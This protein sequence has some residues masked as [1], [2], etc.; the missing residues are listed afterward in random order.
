MT[1]ASASSAAAVPSDRSRYGLAAF[2]V[3]AGVMH[4]VSPG[5]FERIVP[6]WIG[7]EKAV[8]A[9]S[10][11]AEV[12]CGVLLAVP[13]TRRFGAWLTVVTLVAVYPANLQMAVDAGRPQE[14]A[15]WVAWL[16]LPLQFPLIVWA[17]HHTR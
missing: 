15:D 6:K 17:H 10:G 4:F 8:V 9:W 1:S 13:R 3:G 12:L 14:A 11:A 16:R 7:H 5:F 2:M